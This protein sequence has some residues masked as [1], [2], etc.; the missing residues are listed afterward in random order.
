MK[1]INPEYAKAGLV[2][3]GLAWAGAS[4]GELAANPDRLLLPVGRGVLLGV[5]VVDALKGSR[6]ASALLV[7]LSVVGLSLGGLWIT[8]ILMIIGVILFL[9]AGG[10][11]AFRGAPSP[12]SRRPNDTENLAR[13]R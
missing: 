13:V 4:L 2:F 5:L 9:W 7:G 1:A 12:A 8:L 6:A 3:S 10:S 11:R